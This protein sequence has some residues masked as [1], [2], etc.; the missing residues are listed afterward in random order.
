MMKGI[1]EN[2]DFYASKSRKMVFGM[3]KNRFL[4]GDMMT[5]GY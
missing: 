5:F 3:M 4:A 2:D 1:M